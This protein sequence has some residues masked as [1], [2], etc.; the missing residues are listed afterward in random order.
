[1]ENA[2][3]GF[4]SLGWVGLETEYELYA[5]LNAIPYHSH[6]FYKLRL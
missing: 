5:R 3:T 6:C 4:D 2:D 1:M